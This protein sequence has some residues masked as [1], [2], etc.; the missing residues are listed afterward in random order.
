MFK[1]N[2]Y[3]FWRGDL[4]SWQPWRLPPSSGK[5]DRGLP[6][7]PITPINL[8]PVSAGMVADPANTLGQVIRSLDWAGYC[9]CP[10]HRV[11]FFWQ[12]KQ[13]TDREITVRL[14]TDHIADELVKERRGNRHN[15]ISVGND[16]CKKS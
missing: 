9:L 14:L 12:K 4:S 1:M 16:R 11:Y 2:D 6:R 13:L 3:S 7:L 15:G 5:K 10:Q 8:T